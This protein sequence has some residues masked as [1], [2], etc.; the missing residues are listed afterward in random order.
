MLRRK[1]DYTAAGVKCENDLM[2]NVSFENGD[3]TSTECFNKD[4][5]YTFSKDRPA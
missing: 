3:V 4:T 2:N 1:T 5:F